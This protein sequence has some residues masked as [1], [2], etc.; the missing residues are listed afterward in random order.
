MSSGGLYI[1]EIFTVW[2]FKLFIYH[3]PNEKSDVRASFSHVECSTPPFV[4]INNSVVERNKYF[5]LQ[6]HLLDELESS[7]PYK[8]DGQLSVGS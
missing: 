8:E 1:I 6:M 2:K 5:F 4:S 7:I 3:D